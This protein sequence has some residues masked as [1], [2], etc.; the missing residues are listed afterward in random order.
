MKSSLYFFDKMLREM[1]KI[2]INSL[3]LKRFFPVSSAGS[4]LSQTANWI[5]N[6][7]ELIV[8]CD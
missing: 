8:L 1:L 2:A 5:E 7:L 3:K 4:N 6:K